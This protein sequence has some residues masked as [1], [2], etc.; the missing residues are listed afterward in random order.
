MAVPSDP[1]HKLAACRV[2]PTTMDEEPLLVVEWHKIIFPPETGRTLFP[3]T[4]YGGD[5]ARTRYKVK[6]LLPLSCKLLLCFISLQ[7]SHT[8]IVLYK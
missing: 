4:T 5:V 7:M 2:H 1:A 8:F 3:L 6:K